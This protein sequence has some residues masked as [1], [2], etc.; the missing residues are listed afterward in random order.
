M[1]TERH[2]GSVGIPHWLSRAAVATREMIL[3]TKFIARWRQD[4]LTGR[5]AK[6][7]KRDL[8]KPGQI[9]G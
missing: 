1:G 7:G 4:A 8:D 3:K 6:P 5:S 9:P 2:W